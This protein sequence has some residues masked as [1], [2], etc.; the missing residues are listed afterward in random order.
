MSAPDERPEHDP[1]LEADGGSY[2]PTYEEL[3]SDLLESLEANGLVV[4]DVRHELEPGTGERRFECVARLP[5]GDSPHRYHATLHF[6]W[7]AL[8][9]YASAYGPGAECDLY[10]G[11]DVPCPHREGRPQPFTEIVV[12]YTLGDGGY[13][14]RDLSEVPHWIETARQLLEKAAAGDDRPAVH[15]GLS[16][17]GDTTLVERFVAESSW[18]LELDEPP[19]L[20]PVSRQVT[21]TLRLTPGLAD[22]LPF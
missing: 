12:E 17:Q 2:F 14:L 13:Q 18:Y 5:G 19:D 16:W 8:L 4:H 10:H 15:I 11:D 3:A 9:T 22:R 21:A 1:E 7:D 20:G 6:H